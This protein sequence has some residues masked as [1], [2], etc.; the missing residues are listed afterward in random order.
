MDNLFTNVDKHLYMDISH[1]LFYYE[2]DCDDSRSRKLQGRECSLV[3][4]VPQ[5][6]GQRIVKARAATCSMHCSLCSYL[7]AICRAPPAAGALYLHGCGTRAFR[8]T[9]AT[10]TARAAL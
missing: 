9:V 2:C 7:K 4:R 6:R 3:A 8:T 1:L 5:T 10:V